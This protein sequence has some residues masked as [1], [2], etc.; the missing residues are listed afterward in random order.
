MFRFNP[1]TSTWKLI[2]TDRGYGCSGPAVGA[3]GV[4]MLG[5][6]F[7]DFIVSAAEGKKWQ[8]PSTQ[9]DLDP[10][11]IDQK[12]LRI[13]GEAVLPDGTILA[14]QEVPPASGTAGV[15]YTHV[16]KLA[17]PG[18]P[19]LDALPF[20]K[21][22]LG[23]EV[24]T[25]LASGGAG[26]AAVGVTFLGGQPV[27]GLNSELGDGSGPGQLLL[28]ASDASVI[29]SALRLPGQLLGMSAV[30]G[31]S[32]NRVAF[33]TNTTIGVADMVSGAIAWQLPD[34]ASSKSVDASTDG[35]TIVVACNKDVRLLGATDGTLLR[36]V[37]LAR[38]YVTDVA[39]S[40]SHGSFYVTGFDN[41]RLPSGSPVQVAWLVAYAI[42]DGS[43]RWQ[44]FGFNGADLSANI[45]DTR[46]YRVKLGGDGQTLD[47]LGESAGSQTIFR[48]DGLAVSGPVMLTSIDFFTDLW[49]TASAHI[50]YAARVDAAT[51][52][53]LASQLTMARLPDGKSNTFRN[54]DIASDADGR[55]FFGGACTYQM[56][57]RDA[58]T[59]NGVPVGPYKAADPAFV[60]LSPD[61]KARYT[62]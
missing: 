18:Y 8:L 27:V 53:I 45:A 2:M 54:G 17:L 43:F 49:N 34:S 58:L 57:Q 13:A 31:S 55:L 44:R 10:L 9:A 42:T 14:A 29:V 24:G 36:Q 22:D 61:L 33:V 28:L 52:A 15:K 37:T 40:S 19:N 20:T 35:S 59:V 30:G 4:L 39:I 16:L 38:D 21:T 1:G 41:K 48:F 32:S 6:R 12:G 3:S 26:N 46:L 23:L 25:Y 62:W 5:G 51:G 50:S 56:A 47:L 11:Q 60:A 7:P